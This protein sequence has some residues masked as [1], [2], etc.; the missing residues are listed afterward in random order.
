MKKQL[1]SFLLLITV[2]FSSISCSPQVK[3]SA[4]VELTASPTVLPTPTTQELS[5]IKYTSADTILPFELTPELLDQ[6]NSMPAASN[7]SLPVWHGMTMD[8][9]GWLTEAYH[10]DFM[11]Y[12]QQDV[13]NAASLGFNFVRAPLDVSVLF[14]KGD[15]TQ[16]N[17]GALQ[18]MDNL[19]V[20]GIQNHIHICFDVHNTPGFSTDGNDTNDTLFQNEDQQQVF[21]NFWK[22]IAQRYAAVPNNALSFDLLNEPHGDTLDDATYSSVMLKAIDTIRAITPDRL[23]F[24]DM[25]VV[26]TVPVQGLV[27]SGVVQAIHS[28]IPGFNEDNYS[29]TNFVMTQSWPIYVINGMVKKR[30]GPMVF[31]GHF[32]AGTKIV[33]R[34]GSFQKTGDIVVTSN[35]NEIGRATFGNEKPGQNHC[36]FIDGE[37]SDNE[38]RN[39]TGAG[40]EVN[41][42]ADTE[43][44]SIDLQGKSDWY[45][46][47][48]ISIISPE[49][50]VLIITQ[51]FV[52]DKDAPL[53]FT[54]SDEGELTAKDPETLSTIDETYYVN[55]MQEYADFAKKNGIQIMVQ[56][57]GIDNRVDYQVTLKAL[58]AELSAFQKTGLNWCL[59]DKGFDYLATQDKYRREGATYQQISEDRFIAVEMVDI[60]KKYIQ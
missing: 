16:I 48:G 2:L 29:G 57:F 18:N 25:M 59:W 7:S 32:P 42:P 5:F 4:V 11:T 30:N 21:V 33:F 47:F 55:R 46:L 1:V 8:N 27:A 52:Q 44:I 35:N 15:S 12:Q 17:P 40:F 24:A 14:K 28:Y 54:L 41:V 10:V 23:I 38:Y 6:A 19:V 3:P 31:N 13:L 60:L 53:E 26:G 45:Y 37:G 9:M 49:H 20:W 43:Q 34:V 56:E 39:Y 58:D 22:F 51:D 50:N 36:N